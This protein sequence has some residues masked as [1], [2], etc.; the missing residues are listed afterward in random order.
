MAMTLTHPVKITTGRE[1]KTSRSHVEATVTTTSRYVRNIGAEADIEFD[2]GRRHICVTLRGDAL[3]QIVKHIA[4]YRRLLDRAHRHARMSASY[5]VDEAYEEANIHYH[6]AITFLEAAQLVE[7]HG[8]EGHEYK[9]HAQKVLDW[10]DAEVERLEAKPP[11][12]FLA[13]D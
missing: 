10:R 3:D 12:V 11:Q 13:T 1:R 2:L 4:G 8:Y 7:D 5:L 6:K 9:D